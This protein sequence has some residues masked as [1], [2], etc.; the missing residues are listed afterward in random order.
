MNNQLSPAFSALW[1]PPATNNNQQSQIDTSQQQPNSIISPI[2]S[3]TPPA[4]LYTPSA[5]LDPTATPT[6][7]YSLMDSAPTSESAAPTIDPFQISVFTPSIVAS[8][9]TTVF[10]SVTESSLQTA[11]AADVTATLL[12]SLETT[13]IDASSGN[14]KNGTPKSNLGLIIGLTFLGV[15][16]IIGKQLF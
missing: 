16:L 9:S 14:T 3:Y 2:I 12:P 11:T 15:F 8:F 4:V 10:Q 13:L 7:Y 6:A 5:I 1:L